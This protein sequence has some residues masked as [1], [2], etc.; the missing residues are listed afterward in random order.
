MRNLRHWHP[1]RIAPMV[2][3]A[4]IQVTSSTPPS[5]IWSTFYQS[6]SKIRV[7]FIFRQGVTNCVF[8]CSTLALS[9]CAAFLIYIPNSSVDLPAKI[10]NQT[11]VYQRLTVPGEGDNRI[12]SNPCR[13]VRHCSSLS[14]A[15]GAVQVFASGLSLCLLQTE[16]LLENIS[17]YSYPWRS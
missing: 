17:F 8:S 11:G 12:D 6:I 7:L 4:I 3:D 13:P 1:S 15:G 16:G 10:G 14:Y 2:D 5:P 9:C